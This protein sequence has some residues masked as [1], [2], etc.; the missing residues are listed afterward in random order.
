[1]LQHL[2]GL[3]LVAVPTGPPKGSKTNTGSIYL[4]KL[5]KLRFV[6]ENGRLPVFLSP[7]RGLTKKQ[8]HGTMNEY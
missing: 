3:V 2:L 8:K 6:D 7:I 5:K 1:V 4:G